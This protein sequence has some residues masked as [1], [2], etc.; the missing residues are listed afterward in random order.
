NATGLDYACLGNHEFDCGND[1]LLARMK[2][3][4]F[5]WLGSNVIER[6]TDKPFNG[7]P[8][9]IIRKIG[10][11]KIGLF[12]LLTTDTQ[13]SSKPGPNLRFVDPV[14]MTRRLV[15][16]MRAKGAKVIIALTHST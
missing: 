6:N 1:V 3:S 7:M 10:G 4:N 2:E 12:G 13:T 14:L 8:R 16:E 9:Y 5:V 15:K 11:V